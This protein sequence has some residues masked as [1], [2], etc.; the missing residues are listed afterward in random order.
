MIIDELGRG[1][2]TSDGFG[3]AWSIASYIHEQIRCFCLFATHFHEMTNL[4]K[5]LT[6]ITNYYVTAEI[7]NNKLTM[8][9]NVKEGKSNKSYGLSVLEML[10]FPQNII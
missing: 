5:E 8:L 9:Y 10:N 3:L 7:K 1:T 4:E 6:G 2:S